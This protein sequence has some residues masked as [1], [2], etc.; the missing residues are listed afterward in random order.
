MDKTS[1]SYKGK[2]K[3]RFHNSN[4][5]LIFQMRTHNPWEAQLTRAGTA[6][7][8]KCNGALVKLRIVSSGS[9]DCGKCLGS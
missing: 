9:S 3:Q 4:V 6:T 2:K 1:I 7:N 8:A 5:L